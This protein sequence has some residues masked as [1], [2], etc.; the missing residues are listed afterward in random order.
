MPRLSDLLSD[1]SRKDLISEARKK[2][3]GTQ[4]KKQ[5][6]TPSPGSHQSQK[7]LY[8][9]HAGT[10]PIP[11]FV[12]L[13]V[14]TTGL[15]FKS[16]RIIEIGA[17]KFIDGK[18]TGEFSTFV[19][20][21]VAIPGHITD[22]TGIRNEDIHSAPTFADIADKLLDFIGI[23]PLCGH[24]V[25]F[26]ATFI[27]EEFKRIHREPM[28]RQLIDT[29]LFSRILLGPDQRFSLKS[30]SEYL[31]VNLNNAHRALNDARAS[32][33]VAVAL[34]PKLAKLPLHI[35]QTL[36]YCAPTSF[37]KGLIIKSLGHNRPTIIIDRKRTDSVFERLHE[38]ESYQS[39]DS[40]EV[41][42]IF[43][44]DGVLKNHVGNFVY[45]SSQEQMACKVLE[46]L[47]DQSILI[48]EAGTGTGKSLAYLIPAAVWALKNRCRVVVSTRTKNLQDQLISKD[49]PLVRDAVNGNITFSVLKGRSNYICLSQWKRV[50]SGDMG[51]LSPRERFAILPLI[52]W[53]ESTETGDI[54]EQNQF[55][56]KWFSKIWN[57]ISSE[58]HECRGRRC[59]HYQSC[60]YQNARAKALS[61]NIL[62]INHALFYSD[63]CSENS[64][65]GPIG[66]IIFDEAH[67]LE[68]SGHRFL[69]VELDTNRIN[70]LTEV[71]NSLVLHIGNLQEEKQIYSIGKEIRSLLKQFR[72]HS[73]D[74]LHELSTWAAQNQNLNEFQIGY[75]STLFSGL[76]RS[77][78]FEHSINEISDQLYALKQAIT[79]HQQADAFKE[80]EEEAV[81]CSER[82]SQLK[83]DYLYLSQAVTEDHVFWL[84]GNLERGW[85]KACGVPLD[86]STILSDVWSRCSGGIVFTSATLSVSKS[87]SY[88]KNASGIGPHDARTAVELFKSPFGAHQMIMGSISSAPEVDSPEY[89]KYVA[90]AIS[91]IHNE[92]HKNILVLFTA[93]S[94]QSAVYDL[95]KSDSSIDNH[96]LLAQGTSG[97]RHAI[98]DQFK[99]NSSMIL[100]GTD[101]FWEGIDAPGESCEV[102]IIP[103]LPFPVPTHPLT[104]AVCKR[105]EG[106][107][108]ESFFSYS[109]P[110]AVIKFRQGAG[111]LIRTTTDRGALVVLDSRIITKGYGK[112]FI[113][114]L[115]GDF[116]TFNDSTSMVGA[117]KE[118][119]SNPDGY[120]Q[121]SEKYV[122][123]EE[124]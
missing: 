72:K 124:V 76:L 111:R 12:A 94:M 28:S 23:F 27:N 98:L 105:V 55:N 2:E 50:L 119:F 58:S 48:A 51:N 120:E 40:K 93:S 77:A 115:D 96:K 19:N 114:S 30:V 31:S 47:N 46:S 9:E 59:A 25:E 123:L 42:S 33:E 11:D 110:E 32:G 5:K 21:G 39:I 121:S 15:D 34:I 112:Q 90:Q 89:P 79:G 81:T 53:V 103:R 71:L 16:D 67:H 78:V 106:K 4:Q 62:V 108:G 116:R 8:A 38:P 99:K 75:D 1:R 13:D 63:L 83:A 41:K 86:I 101:S 56:P 6:H 18:V 74:F 36:A 52:P 95:L 54:E 118:F 107:N 49:L 113:R 92:L 61:S 73:Q 26:D 69:R 65:L 14:E 35:R 29:A 84:E 45:R 70:L 68:T 88:F 66:S 37:F 3:Q 60:F 44:T 85:V 10:F 97:A 22:L 43:S 24:Q 17:V 122:P 82:I 109:I 64:F 87:V 100:L 7:H 91:R 20:A 102:V 80:L 104:Q 57:V 117:V